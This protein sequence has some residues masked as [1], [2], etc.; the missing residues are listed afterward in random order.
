M[1]RDIA[2]IT[3]EYG[4][5]AKEQAARNYINNT[6]IGMSDKD[7]DLLKVL[8]SFDDASGGRLDNFYQLYKTI[9]DNPPAEN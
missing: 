9:K 4:R 2:E 1:R 5:K 8:H 7:K 6:L 3:R